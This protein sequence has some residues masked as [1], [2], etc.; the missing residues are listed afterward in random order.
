MPWIV[1]Q[2]PISGRSEG[3]IGTIIY[4]RVHR[5]FFFFQEKKERKCG[6]K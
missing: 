5:L 1:Y 3:S 6:E 2:R 4:F